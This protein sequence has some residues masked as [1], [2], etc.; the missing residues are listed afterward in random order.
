MLSLERQMPHWEGGCSS[1]DVELYFDRRYRPDETVERLWPLLDELGIT[2]LARQTGLD[3]IGIP[4]WAA[5]RPNSRSLAGAQGKG[6]SD[7]AACA[8]ALMEAAEVAV[9]EHPRAGRRICSA[10]DLEASDEAWFDPSRFMAFGEALDPSMRLTWLAGEDLQSRRRRWVP[11]DL[12]DMDG[13]ASEIE[14][15]CKSSNGLASGNTVE[16]ATFHAL[17]ELIERDATTTWSMLPAPERMA[18][19]FPWAKLDDPLVDNLAR[20]ILSADLSLRLVD[21]TSDLGI[22]VVMALVGPADPHAARY[23]DV[24]AGYGAHPVAA[25]AALRALT[26]AAQS[27]ITAIAASRDDLGPTTFGAEAA[28]EDASILR[29]EPTAEPPCGVHLGAPLDVLSRLCAE[30]LHRKDIEATVVRV[31]GGDL[32]FAVVKMLSRDL[33]DRGAN[34]NWR[35]GRRALEALWSR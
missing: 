19:A 3:R 9:A 34:L 6:V 11:L 28:A 21:Q 22:P 7:A 20:R 8:S 15:I 27:R 13:E 18:R 33:E 35:P 29:D 25:R 16:E 23:L 12:V 14:G 5:F 30:A 1:G 24:C 4:C 10:H 2:R 32:P 17:C 31:D 26:E